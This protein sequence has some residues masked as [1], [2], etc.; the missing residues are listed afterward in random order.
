M[1]S[2]PFRGELRRGGHRIFGLGQNEELSTPVGAA[3]TN[4]SP[5]KVALVTSVIGAATGWVIEEFARF[6]RGK[7]RS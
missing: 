3:V 5:W 7:H 1:D 6:T 2:Q 4:P